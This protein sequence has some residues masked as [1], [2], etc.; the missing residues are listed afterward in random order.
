[1]ELKSL[2]GVFVIDQ[3]SYALPLNFVLSIES[4][5]AHEMLNEVPHVSFQDVL[6]PVHE[7]V[8]ETQD[9]EQEQ[10]REL[11]LILASEPPKALQVDNFYSLEIDSNKIRPL[12][13][14]MCNEETLINTFYLGESEE[15]TTLV[16]DFSNLDS[17]LDARNG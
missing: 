16:L 6:I 9:Q 4:T 2:F 15:K 11:A 14:A 12:P 7:L 8:G 3:Q 10:V 13:D 5:D 17:F 1:M